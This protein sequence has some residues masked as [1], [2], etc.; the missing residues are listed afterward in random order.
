FAKAGNIINIDLEELPVTTYTKTLYNPDGSEKIYL[1]PGLTAI[2]LQVQ[3]LLLTALA[4]VREREQGT[5]EQLIVTPIKSWELV[6]GKIIPYLFVGILNT[7]GSL[8]ISIYIFG[9]VVQGSFWLLV[10]LTIPFIVG[11]LGMG[12]LISNI[13][14]TQ[15]QAMYLAVGIILIP[16]IILSGLIYSRESMPAFTYYFSELLPVTH[17]LVII[18]G[19]M[20]K[21]VGITFLMPSIIKEL[22]LGL[23]Y[24]IAS[25]LAFRKKI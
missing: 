18:R 19:I 14:R 20:V 6:L 24:F 4:I 17:Y 12:V 21:G 9:I 15:M 5:M 1:I 16:A 23:F 2:V 13:S 25:V 22:A 3:A 11:S 8:L 10:G 7:I